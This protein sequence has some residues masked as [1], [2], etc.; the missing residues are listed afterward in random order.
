MIIKRIFSCKDHTVEAS[1][2]GEELGRIDSDGPGKN[3]LLRK[4]YASVG[5]VTEA[6][7]KILDDTEPGSSDEEEYDPYNSGRF[8]T[9]KMRWSRS[10][11]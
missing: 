8:D 10:H 11:K 7:L 9:S 5:T 2:D 3:V 6:D 4:K 1:F